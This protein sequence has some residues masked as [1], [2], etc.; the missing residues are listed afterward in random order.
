MPSNQSQ[1]FKEPGNC[2]IDNLCL[3]HQ[4]ADHVGDVGDVLKGMHVKRLYIPAG[5]NENSQFM[6][7]IRANVKD[8]QIIPVSAGQKINDTPFTV[9][10]P[11]KPG[12]GTNEDSMVLAGKIADLHG[13]LPVIWIKQGAWNLSSLSCFAQTC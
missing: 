7:R 12:L 5:M 13:C 11:F 2:H 4:D 6:K 9:V 1:L 3:S 10:H 8:T